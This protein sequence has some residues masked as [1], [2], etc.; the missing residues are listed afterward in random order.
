MAAAA[1]LAALA[2]FLSRKDWT[3]FALHSAAA[4]VAASHAIITINPPAPDWLPHLLER[5]VSSV[6]LIGVIDDDPQL[7]D[8]TMWVFPVAIEGV[9]QTVDWHRASGIVEV[10][11]KVATNAAPQSFAYGQRWHFFGLISARPSRGNSPPLTMRARPASSQFLG[12]G[13]HSKFYAWCLARRKTASAILGLGLREKDFP[14]ELAMMRALILGERTDIDP[15]VLRAFQRTGTLHIVAISGSHVAVF[16]ALI[17]AI[18]RAFGFSRMSWALFA[19]PVLIVYTTLAGLPSSAVRSCIMA[20]VFMSAP[21]LRRRTDGATALALSALLVL[22]VAPR[23]LFDPGF[24]LSFFAVGGLMLFYRPIFLWLT[25]W[26]PDPPPVEV[27][28]RFS[29]FL[30]WGFRETAALF[31]VT[32]AA[33]LVS[34]PLI[35]MFFHIRS[36]VALLANIAVVPLAFFILVSGC[37]A[38][39]AGT[40]WPLAAEVF[41][42]ADRVF[43]RTM[44]WIVEKSSA[45]P[46]AYQFVKSPPLYWVVVFYALLLLLFFA[47]GRLRRLSAALAAVLLATWCGDY[48]LNCRASAEWLSPSESPVMFLDLPRDQDVLV[49]TGDDFCAPQIVRFLH[50]RG[51]DHLRALIL[52]RPVGEVLGGATNLLAEVAADEIWV[53]SWRGRSKISDAFLEDCKRRGIAVRTL[54]RGDGGALAGGVRWE[55]LH[56]QAGTK[57]HSAAGGGLVLRFARGPSA[58]LFAGGG[59]EECERDVVTSQRDAGADV[60]L[61]GVEAKKSWGPAF[62]FAVHPRSIIFRPHS[63]PGDAEAALTVSPQT[64]RA[65][66]SPV[67]RDEY[68]RMNFPGA[69]LFQSLEAI[70]AGISN[71]WKSRNDDWWRGEILPLE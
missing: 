14:Q 45:L 22:A 71:H 40:F 28:S 68:W 15:G 66:I 24:L 50:S 55:I 38:L 37:L 31:A 61:A 21:T 7:R 51:V 16:F 35:G 6:D 2:F 4:L 44:L 49:N 5:P 69:D 20:I 47:R 57:Y 25:S 56:P 1:L 33:W 36:P 27:V 58:I 54:Q 34:E 53:S 17:T 42:H 10:R 23:D 19:A 48:F 11:L 67:H 30:R 13:P 46:G 63:G 9:Q 62:L 60:L 43:V 8:G 65:E 3:D 59:G 26:L 39:V 52:T 32:L 64:L 41:N 18:L 29:R 12:S 70:A